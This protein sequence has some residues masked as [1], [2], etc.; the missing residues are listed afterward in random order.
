M[1]I[2]TMT[3]FAK[4]R[5]LGGAYNECMALLPDGGWAAFLDH[6]A[7]F[8]TREW[9]GQICEAV[10]F[11]PRAMFTAM[12]NR[13]ASSWQ[14]AAESDPNN[15]DMAYHRKLGAARL[16]KRTLLDA[17]TTKGIGGVL[18]VISK[19][20]W[21]DVGGFV[22]GMFCVDHNMHFAHAKAGRSVYVIES[23]Y[24]YHWR[25]ANG[26]TIVETPKAPCECRGHEV[27]PTVRLALP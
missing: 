7:G 24:L 25:R 18:M 3:P 1:Q 16:A 19:E 6:D 26:D 17:T 15:H 11:Q 12:T 20:A 21:R 9:Y 23:L 8:T 22:P 4:D 27:S 5:N 13:I 10:A 2:F 14:R